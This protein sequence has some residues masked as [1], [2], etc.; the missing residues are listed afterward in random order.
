VTG[1]FTVDGN[2]NIITGSINYNFQGN[3]CSGPI[4]NGEYHVATDGQGDLTLNFP[5]VQPAFGTQGS[6]GLFG[7]GSSCV[8]TL[9]TLSTALGGILNNIAQIVQLANMVAVVNEGVDFQ[10]VLSGVA[11]R[12]TAVPSTSNTQ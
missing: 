9:M 2:G 7:G 11:E 3:L 12:Q 4:T 8:F 6:G 1:V 5:F 10:L